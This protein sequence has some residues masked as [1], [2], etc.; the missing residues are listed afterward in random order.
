[1]PP[2]SSPSPIRRAHPN[3]D[4]SAAKQPVTAEELLA[5]KGLWQLES[6][7]GALLLLTKSTMVEVHIRRAAVYTMA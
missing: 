2:I 5:R 4:G 1:M 6:L 7:L 3:W